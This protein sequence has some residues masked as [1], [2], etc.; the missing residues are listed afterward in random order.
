VVLPHATLVDRGAAPATEAARPLRI[1]YA[2][3]PTAHKGWEIFRA[4]LEK[5]GE[6]PRYGFLHLGGRTVPGLPLEFHKVTVTEATPR[7]MQEAIER[8]GLRNDL[9]LGEYFINEAGVA[10]VPGSAFG[11]PG[12]MRLSFATSMDNIQAGLKRIGAA[13]GA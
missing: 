10:L 12:C 5:H 4:L 1:A 2:G 9:E 11:A 7:A 13:L 8:L 3:M 6:N